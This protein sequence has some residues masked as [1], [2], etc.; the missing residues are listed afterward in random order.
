MAL[1]L[2]QN[3][4]SATPNGASQTFSRIGRAL[5]RLV[6][7]VASIALTF[8]GLTAI[9]FFIGRVMPLDPVLAIV[10]DRAPQ[11][12][13]DAV[14]AD[15][16]LDQPIPVQYVRFLGDILQGDFGVSV[17]TSR[18]VIE[19][20]WRA[21]PATLEL[22]TL[23]TLIGV[24][25][26]VPMGVWAAV[27]QGALVDHLVRVFGLIGYSTPI[28][29]LGMIGLLVFYAQLQLTPGPGRLSVFYDGIVEPWSGLLLLDAALAGEWT[30]FW[31]AV[32]HITLPSAMLGTFALAYIARMTRSFMLEQ[33]RQEYVLT[34][35]AKGLSELSVIWRHA[36][37]NVLVQ[38]ITIIG[39][40]YAS[41]L[42]GSVLT[43]TVF[44]WPGIGQYITNALFNSDMN[45]VIGG[46]IVVG[47]CFV[48]VN[49]LSD[50]L[51]RLVDPRTRG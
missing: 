43:E 16:G 9:T 5:L 51:Y 49:M 14:Y 11:E 40:T 36:F 48:G 7:A 47:V 27:R 50:Q 44:A 8:I 20:L 37:G 3:N 18:P 26:G 39:L 29:W 2:P 42:E 41:L 38:L 23:A 25:L 15:L 12:V 21:F 35:R 30:V 17:Q 22:A 1:S 45:A 32:A 6:S 33:L 34:A 31:D 28:F 24:V 10:G 4:G 46:T 13:Y 19:D